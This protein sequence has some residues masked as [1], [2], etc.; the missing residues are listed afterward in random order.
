MDGGLLNGSLIHD[1]VLLIANSYFNKHNLTNLSWSFSYCICPREWIDFL[2]DLDWPNCRDTYS[3]FSLL[4]SLIKF[5]N[6]FV[7][8]RTLCFWTVSGLSII[9]H[10]SV[11]FWISICILKYCRITAPGEVLKL[12]LFFFSVVLFLFYMYTRMCK[13]ENIHKH[14]T[15]A[16][17][18]N[19]LHL[20]MYSF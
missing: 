5:I 8:V 15:H 2:L 4:P 13:L 10:K 14:V 20:T 18:V 11:S 9:K 17:T 16:C 19:V 1:A 12:L 7:N 6:A 3:F